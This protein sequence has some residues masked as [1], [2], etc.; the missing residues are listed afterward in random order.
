MGFQ[1]IKN[2]VLKGFF[3]GLIA[4]TFGLVFAIQIFGSSDD[5]TMVVKEAIKEGFLGKLMSIG[6]LLN[7]GA[8]FIFLKKKQDLRARG[9]LISTVLVL[10]FTLIIKNFSE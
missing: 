5:Y 2:E 3:V 6:A 10:I 1:M 7:L 8:F 9:V 4:T